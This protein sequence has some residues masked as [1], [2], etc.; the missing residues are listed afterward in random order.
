[1]AL[2]LSED[3]RAEDWTTGK[4]WRSLVSVRTEHETP[5]LFSMLRLPEEPNVKD[6]QRSL[7]SF[8]NPSLEPVFA[9]QAGHWRRQRPENQSG[10]HS[11]T[12]ISLFK[13]PF[14]RKS[15]LRMSISSAGQKSFDAPGPSS[16]S[17]APHGPNPLGPI[18]PVPPQSRPAAGYHLLLSLLTLAHPVSS[19]AAPVGG[20]GRRHGPRRVFY[21]SSRRGLSRQKSARAPR[22]GLK[23]NPGRPGRVGGAAAGQAEPAARKILDRDLRTAAGF[24]RAAQTRRGTQPKPAPGR[25]NSG[26][27]HHAHLRAPTGAE[28]AAQLRRNETVAFWQHVDG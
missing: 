18:L 23:P 12:M 13:C 9:P 11:V 7:P 3:Q 1:M 20:P 21:L 10:T 17:A 22:P 4:P 19:A 28:T 16:A 5:A 2:P 15:S 27:A 6:T 26:P 24:S 25:F 14:L 8:F